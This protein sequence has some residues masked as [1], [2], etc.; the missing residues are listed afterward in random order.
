MVARLVRDPFDREGWLFELKWDGFRAIAER[1]HGGHVSLYS[2][3]QNDFKKRFPAIVDALEKLKRPAILDGEIVALDDEGFPRFEW[4][5]NRG[6]AGKGQLICFVFDLLYL[7]G[8]D[9]RPLPLKTR[10]SRLKKIVRKLPNVLYLD[11]IEEH[12]QEFFHLA[13]HV[14][15]RE[16]WR[17]I[18]KAL[19]SKAPRETWH[20]QKIKNRDYQRKGKVEF[21]PTK[22]RLTLEE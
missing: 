3:N 17:R 22:N 19:T 11:H 16:S 13:L 15:L 4:M 8:E 9:L 10:K 7:D 5:V 21:H 18:R 12:G 1:D 14:D 20:W 2:R 6:A